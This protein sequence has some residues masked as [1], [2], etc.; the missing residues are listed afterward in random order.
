M[1]ISRIK[2]SQPQHIACCWWH[3]TPTFCW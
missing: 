3:S 2:N 1:I